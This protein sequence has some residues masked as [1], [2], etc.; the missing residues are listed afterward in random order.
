MCCAHFQKLKIVYFCHNKDKL[1]RFEIKFV[2]QNAVFF[3]CHPITLNAFLYLLWFWINR[4]LA[5][6][7]RCS[8]R[9]KR[10]QCRCLKSVLCGVVNF[11]G[12]TWNVCSHIP[13]TVHSC[14]RQTTK[15]ITP[16]N[17]IMRQK[18]M[19]GNLFGDG[20][21]SINCHFMFRNLL[22]LDTNRKTNHHGQKRA[23]L[24]K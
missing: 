22:W 5:W 17:N 7:S 4:H 13:C 21:K 1:I 10:K 2:H 24:E 3:I 18:K 14:P 19:N 23:V 6:P 16:F 8:F 20:M 15:K 9:T 11:N 12:R